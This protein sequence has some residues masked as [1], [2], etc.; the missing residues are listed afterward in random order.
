MYSFAVKELMCLHLKTNKKANEILGSWPETNTV[1]KRDIGRRE[2]R[3]I[4]AFTCDLHSRALQIKAFYSYHP[5]DPYF[6]KE[7]NHLRRNY[8]LLTETSAQLD[9]RFCNKILRNFVYDP[10]VHMKNFS[11]NISHP[12][13]RS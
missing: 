10:L 7:S 8:G 1:R 11:S 3:V 12:N 9:N 13:I 2:Q 5:L 4:N 6:Q